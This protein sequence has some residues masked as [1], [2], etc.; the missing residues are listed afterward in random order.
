MRGTRAGGRDADGRPGEGGGDV[1]LGPAIRL[2]SWRKIAMGTWRTVGDPGLLAFALNAR[3]MHTFGRTGLAPERA[4][5]GTELVT[6]AARHSRPRPCAGSR[7]RAS[8]SET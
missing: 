1:E 6:V 8:S 5:I 7:R 4:A 3:F 2:T